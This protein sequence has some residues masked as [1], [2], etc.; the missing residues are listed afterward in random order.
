[1]D[2]RDV[3]EAF[4]VNLRR[5]RH[6]AFGSSLPSPAGPIQGPMRFHPIARSKPL[7]LP[8]HPSGCSAWAWSGLPSLLG[9]AG[10]RGDR[11]AF[12]CVWCNGSRRQIEPDP[13]E[14]AARYGAGTT[15]LATLRYDRGQPLHCGWLIDKGCCA[16]AD[17]PSGS[18]RYHM[19]RMPTNP[20]G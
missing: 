20:P 2:R 16:L 13:A 19:T 18:A 14:M 11:S 9:V 3:R 10:Q 17:H 7:C 12:R 8:R 15:V 1:M 6:A 4:A 5:L